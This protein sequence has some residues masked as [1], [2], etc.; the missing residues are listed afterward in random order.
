MSDDDPITTSDE[1]SSAIKN[2]A[3]DAAPLSG[4]AASVNGH[5]SEAETNPLIAPAVDD[6]AMPETEADVPS[7]APETEITADDTPSPD[8]EITADHTSTTSDYPATMT[9]VEAAPAA[10]ASLM[11]G[12]TAPLSSR[13]PEPVPDGMEWDDVPTLVLAS[14]GVVALP[15]LPPGALIGD[16]YVLRGILSSEDDQNVYRAENIGGDELYTIVESAQQV[17]GKQQVISQGLSHP[18]LLPVIDLFSHQPY[19]DLVRYYAVSPAAE[20]SVLLSDLNPPL[21]TEQALVWAGELAEVLNY[22]HE[23]GVYSPI[24]TPDNVLIENGHALIGDLSASQ[25][26]T[27]AGEEQETL[28]RHDIAQLAEIVTFALSGRRN[29][30]AADLPALRG[31]DGQPLPIP[32]QAPIVAALLGEQGSARAFYADLYAAWRSVAAPPADLMLHSGKLTHVGMLRRNNQDSLA[33]I[34]CAMM[35][36]SLSGTCGVYVVADGMGG[37]KSGEVAS[38]ITVNAVVANLLTSTITPLYND[39]SADIIA[40]DTVRS[41]L[42]EAV[43]AANQQVNGMRQ[44]EGSDM[45]T[46]VVAALVLDGRIYIGN[47]GDSRAY[48]Y[49]PDVGIHQITT[50]HSLVARLVALGQISEA[51]AAVHPHRHVIFRSLGEKAR[52]DVD[53]FVE[54]V[55]AGDRILLCSDGLSG[56]VSDAEMQTILASEPDPQVVA[57]RFIDL[58]NAHG[59]VDNISVIIVNVERAIMADEQ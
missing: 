59:G 42:A 58:A 34:E 54:P 15:P 17:R 6:A 22:L 23:Q 35:V 14:S 53:T 55:Q 1:Q 9:A 44:R 38:A 28:R 7:S 51:E 33:V 20:E 32:L 47:V 49:R 46:T 13:R 18:H 52:V 45:G 30:S 16:H 8:A 19:D 26:A 39:E 5:E 57:Q 10:A 24:L 25:V 12:G 40:E 29:A 31:S 41:R 36:Q 3:N 43:Q 2:G 4:A 50:D 37:H 56:M 27:D 11:V 48:F 21:P